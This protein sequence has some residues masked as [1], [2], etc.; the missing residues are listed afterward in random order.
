[1]IVSFSLH[2]IIRSYVHGICKL[3]YIYHLKNVSNRFHRDQNKF[4]TLTLAYDAF[5]LEGLGG[6]E[7]GGIETVYSQQ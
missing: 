5:A 4:Y 1:M 2:I 3:P 6:M 7:Q